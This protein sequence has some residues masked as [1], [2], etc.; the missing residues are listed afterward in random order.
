MK[1]TN[2]RYFYNVRVRRS[3]GRKVTEALPEEF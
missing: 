3:K 2:T 1:D